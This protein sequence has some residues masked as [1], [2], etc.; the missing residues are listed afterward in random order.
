VTFSWKIPAAAAGGAFL[1]S[2]LVGVIGRVGFGIAILRGLL[3][4]VIFG[5]LAFG[6]DYLL[7]R[8][9]PELFGD[10][11][12]DSVEDE[13]AVD[14]TLDEE[15][16]L[17]EMTPAVS[18]SDV[19]DDSSE[20][21]NGGDEANTVEEKIPL[22]ADAFGDDSEE[23]GEVEQVGEA[24]E[25]TA[26]EGQSADSVEDEAVFQ[27]DSNGPDDELPSLESV[28]TAFVASGVEEQDDEP[29]E[30]TIDA[31]GIEEDPAIVARAVRTFM[32]K[33]QEG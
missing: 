15:N 33:D 4:A 12:N 22:V 19:T 13:R 29:K 17:T 24:E 11:E 25:I 1:L 30:V 23:I 6:V 10:H 18:E 26:A 28:E 8:F 5:A 20:D 7:R 2:F 16:P 3:W 32:N 31:L 21:P 27:A 9:L 14:I